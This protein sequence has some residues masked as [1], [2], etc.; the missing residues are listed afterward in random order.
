MGHIVFSQLRHHGNTE[1]ARDL[2]H[3]RA[4]RTT[5]SGRGQLG[6]RSESDRFATQ[7]AVSELPCKV[8]PTGLRSER[9]RVGEITGGRETTKTMS[10]V[11]TNWNNWFAAGI[12]PV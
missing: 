6:A 7:V 11:G 3:A 8:R 10:K 5:V 4:S 9:C 1:C 2:L 12:I